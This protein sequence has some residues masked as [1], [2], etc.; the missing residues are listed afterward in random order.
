MSSSGKWDLISGSRRLWSTMVIVVLEAGSEAM[1]GSSVKRRSEGDMENME[2][3]WRSSG[4]RARS[5]RGIER[6]G[7]G[8]GL[9]E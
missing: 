1:G 3:R 9:G 4:R 7:I 2:Q 5:A 6:N 8:E